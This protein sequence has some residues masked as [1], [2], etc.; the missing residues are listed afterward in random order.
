MIMNDVDILLKFAII[1]LHGA[2]NSNIM[3]LLLA[4][5]DSSILS[6]LYLSISSFIHPEI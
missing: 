6:D 1:K 3:H 4:W 2:E 5:I